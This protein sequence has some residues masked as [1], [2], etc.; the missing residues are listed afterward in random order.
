[1]RLFL[2]ILILSLLSTGVN[3]RT[4]SEAMA[5]CEAA[6]YSCMIGAGNYIDGYSDTGSFA[7]RLP[8]DALPCSSV[9][10]VYGTTPSPDASTCDMVV[11]PDCVIPQNPLIA[12]CKYPVDK[13]NGI[14]C[15]DGSTVYPPQICPF[16]LFQ[17]NPKE[18]ESATCA[19]VRVVTYPKTC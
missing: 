13:G 10:N 2:S 3:A 16:S 8:F 15:V 5:Q 4:Y 12:D 7:V 9:S 14:N 18:G 6:G 19:A 11:K 17:A 1:M